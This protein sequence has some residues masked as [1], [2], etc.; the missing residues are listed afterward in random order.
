MKKAAWH[1]CVSILVLFFFLLFV[2]C[3]ADPQ[4]TGTPVVGGPHSPN[5]TR[6]LNYLF[7]QYGKN[8]ISGQMDTAWNPSMDMVASVH[9]DTGKYPALKGF[10]LIQLPYSG[11]PYYAGKEQI[12]EAIEW[13]EGK[14]DGEKLLPGKPDIHGIV[15]F[16]WHWRIPKLTISGSTVYEFYTDRTD[17]RIPWSNDQ[18]DTESA[19]FQTIKD[20]LDKAAALLKLLKD[21]DI[22]VL[23][24]PLHEASGRW[25]WWGASGPQPY[26]ALWE[27]MHNYLT[28]EKG[29]DNLIWVWNGQR[30]DWFPNPKTVDIVGYDRY[31][32]ASTS[33]SARNYSSQKPYFSQTRAMVPGKD[34]M[35]ALTENGAIPD[36]NECYLDEAMWLW[37]MTWNNA[38][39]TNGETHKDNFWTGEYHNTNA[40]KT[41]VYNHARVITLDELPDLTKYRLD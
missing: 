8:I 5:A 1:I 15:A 28:N 31:T 6:L 16:C 7:D 17:F 12:D 11:E 33:Q 3:P 18:L 21:K 32:D 34:R 39:N 25:F 41:Y 14:N 27:Y 40:H 38:R 19:E 29:L 24:R 30:A 2:G 36:P 9:D 22:P 13:W 23:W 35:V 10:D 4:P 37:F 20:D 26:I